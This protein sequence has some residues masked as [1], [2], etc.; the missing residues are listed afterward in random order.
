M[1]NPSGRGDGGGTVWALALLTLLLLQG[2]L[3][4]SESSQTSD[5]AAHLL[6]GYT[7]LRTGNFL[8]Y[9][10]EP[11]LMKEFAALPLLFFDLDLPTFPSREMPRVFLLGPKFLHENRVPGDTILFAARIPM[12]LLSLLLGLAVYLWGMRLYGPRGALLA[13]AL[14][15]F[16]PNVVAHSGVVMTDIGAALFFFLT[17]YGLW[18]WS[19]RPRSRTLILTGLALGGA[20]ASKYTALW[21]VPILLILG[22]ALI[23]TGAPIPARPFGDG[24]G[25]PGRPAARRIGSLALAGLVLAAIAFL[26]VLLSYFGYGLPAYGVGLERGLWHSRTG[27]T[28]YL[29]GHSSPSGFWYYFLFAYLVKTPLGTLAVVAAALLAAA[30]GLRRLPPRDEMFVWAPV[31]VIL[32]I[33]AVWKINIGLRHVLPLYPFLYLAAG[34]MGALPGSGRLRPA[35]RPSVASI[36]VT[37]EAMRP[38][39]AWSLRTLASRLLPG[40]VILAV[41]GSAVEAAAIAPYHLAYFNRLVGGPSRAHLYLLDSNLDWGQAS[42]ALARYVASQGL[43]AIDCSFASNSDPWYYGL[44]YQYVPGIGNLDMS[45]TRGFVLPEGLGRELLAVSPMSLHFVRLGSGTLYNWLK[46]RPVVAMPGYA[47]LVYDLTGDADAHARLAQLYAESGMPA[48]AAAEARRALRLDPGL[49]AARAIL[50][51]LAPP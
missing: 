20:L 44:R 26:I 37:P 15:V 13:L 46:D 14:Y 19:E 3:F 42:R 7:Y 6:A 23:A 45:R 21:L 43:T 22:A 18:C 24:S 49:P 29:M 9:P 17:A 1:A 30:S 31:V 28:G 40:A 12:L 47:Y 27:F 39:G 25:P 16:D 48:L 38:A 2:L 34:R 11:P 32:A 50:E 36:E 8:T 4:I 51:R 41:A 33:T 35:R 5:E 10:G